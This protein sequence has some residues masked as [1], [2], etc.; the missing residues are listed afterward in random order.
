MRDL[1]RFA[2]WLLLGLVVSAAA[3]QAVSGTPS[4][5][6]VAP[7]ESTGDPLLDV[8]PM[9]QGNVTLVGGTVKNIDRVRYRLVVQPFGSGTSMKMTFD[10]RTHIYRDG[11]ET[12]HLG[13]RKGERVYVDTMLDSHRVFARNIRVVTGGQAAD[14]AGQVLSF[15][16]SSGMLMLRDRLSSRDVAVR[17]TPTTMIR[18]NE[19]AGTQ[20]DLK[21]GA[22]VTV[23]FAP[24]R[25]YRGIAREISV[26]AAPGSA[27]LFVGRVTHID[28]RNGVISIE[29]QTDNKL[30]DIHFSADRV[31]LPEEFTI[32]AQARVMATFDG[33]RYRADTLT[34]EQPRSQ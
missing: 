34:V 6:T 18:L 7:A 29:S 17:V 2:S 25:G 3:Q 22:I 10:E 28:L 21:P 1:L 4:T 15:E 12:T 23:K 19:Q 33:S 14:S 8:P 11:I 26:V 5:T 9:P 13:I 32:G 31:R 16:S 24:E 20:A 30:Y 27:F